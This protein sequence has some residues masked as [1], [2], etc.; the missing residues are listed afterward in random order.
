MVKETVTVRPRFK[1]SK[2]DHKSMIHA[3][4]LMGV[5]MSKYIR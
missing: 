2:S 1:L 3:A 5:S 4:G